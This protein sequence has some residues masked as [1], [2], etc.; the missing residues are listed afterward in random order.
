MGC[1]WK[2]SCEYLHV[3]ENNTIESEAVS[4]NIDSQDCDK[5]LVKEMV[6][7]EVQTEAENKCSCEK[8]CDQSDVRIKEDKII[9]VMKRAKC[10]DTEWKEYEEKVE[11]EMDLKD[12]LEDLGKVIEAASRLSEK[13]KVVESSPIKESIE[14]EVQNDSGS[15]HIENT[16]VKNIHIECE[17]KVKEGWKYCEICEYK[18]KKK[19]TLMKHMKTKHRHCIACDECGK[20]VA[21]EDSLN[22]HK[23][24][25]HREDESDQSFIFSE[26]MLD[27]FL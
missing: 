1:H 18:C 22:I 5:E 2:E 13:Q 8:E 26:S 9:C 19:N 16:N 6:E 14:R 25:Y 20:L 15:P 7:K 21:S 10:S 3:L 24:K 11:S 4:I 17:E 12:L 23:E 27:E